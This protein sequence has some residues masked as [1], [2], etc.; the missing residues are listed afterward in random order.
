MKTIKLDLRDAEKR[1]YVVTRRISEFGRSRMLIRCPFCHAES[2]A[3]IWSIAG[4]GKRCE[5]CRAYFFLGEAYRDIVPA[6][7]GAE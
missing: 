1:K 3:Y 6:K 2:W 5:G 4:H 7:G